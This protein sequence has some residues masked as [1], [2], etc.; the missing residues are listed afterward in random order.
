MDAPRGGACQRQAPAPRRSL[1]LGR[2]SEAPLGSWGDG[3]LAGGR[4]SGNPEKAVGPR[5][6]RT[7]AKTLQLFQGRTLAG[8]LPLHQVWGAGP[9]SGEPPCHHLS[10]VV[11][12]LP[13]ASNS[14]LRSRKL[15]RPLPCAPGPAGG[16]HPRPGRSGARPA[17]CLPGAP[18]ALGIDA[19]AG[20][21]LAPA[22]P[23]KPWVSTHGGCGPPG[24]EV[25]WAAARRGGLY[26][27]GEGRRRGG[28]GRG[29]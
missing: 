13:P 12:D 2:H 7:A 6:Q 14:Q 11:H 15:T 27:R 10:Q 28:G 9:T 19:P 24:E 21:A 16:A 18:G 22:P 4:P 20:R 29:R 25:G 3:E 26:A 17:R 23:P 8:S 1:S 5:G